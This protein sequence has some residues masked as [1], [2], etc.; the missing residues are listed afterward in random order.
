MRIHLAVDYTSDYVFWPIFRLDGT[1]LAVEM[2]SHFNGLSGKLSMPADILLMQLSPRQKQDLVHEQLLFI[3]EKSAWFVDNHIQ[4]V[5]KVGREIADILINSDVLRAEIRRLDFV[6][7]E[8]NEFFP[9]LS[10]GKENAALL[11]LSQAFPLW[12]D[13]FGSGKT[14]LK[15]LHDG[16]VQG[17]KLDRQ[18]I[19]QLLSRPANTLMMEP[20]LRTIKNSYSGISIVAK[21]IDTVAILNKMRLLHIDAVQGQMWPAVHF[22]ELDPHT[23]LIG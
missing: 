1:L 2:I 13:N 22:D 3:K 17:V 23:A 20:L 15:P 12:L 4:L 21:E 11:N 19:G 8:I 6:L 9:Q 5:L 7:L 18:F 16:L 10:Q 14:T